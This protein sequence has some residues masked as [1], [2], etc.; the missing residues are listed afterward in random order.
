MF[1]QNHII[2]R[3]YQ[4]YE[5]PCQSSQNSD[6]LSQSSVLKIGQIIPNFFLG[7]QRMTMRFFAYVL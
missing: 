6:F 5:H 2:V 1:S 7:D 3:Q 4:N